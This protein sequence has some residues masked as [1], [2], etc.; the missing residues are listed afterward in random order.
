MTPKHRWRPRAAST[1]AAGLGAALA[2]ATGAPAQ[3]QLIPPLDTTIDVQQWQPAM[4]GSYTKGASGGGTKNAVAKPAAAKRA[5][6]AP[7]GKSKPKMA[8]RKR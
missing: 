7:A 1:L 5:K 8:G 4:E 3:A 6:P 2:L